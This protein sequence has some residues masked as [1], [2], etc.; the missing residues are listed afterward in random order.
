MAAP[1]RPVR[2]AST[3]RNWDRTVR[4][5]VQA[6]LAA[7]AASTKTTLTIAAGPA[8]GGVLSSITGGALPGPVAGEYKSSTGIHAEIDAIN[9][10]V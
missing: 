1:H 6:A 3:R 7:M 5:A 4:G 2:A 9:R 8:G 10:L